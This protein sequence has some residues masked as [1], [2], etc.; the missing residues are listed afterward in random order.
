MEPTGV[1]I[2]VT[3]EREREAGIKYRSHPHH[4]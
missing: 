3:L 1:I 4:D 2:S